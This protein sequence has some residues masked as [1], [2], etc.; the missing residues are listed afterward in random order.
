MPNILSEQDVIEEE[1]VQL[2]KA[3]NSV[4]GKPPER[5]SYT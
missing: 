3:V 2:E 4:K 1:Y 5:W